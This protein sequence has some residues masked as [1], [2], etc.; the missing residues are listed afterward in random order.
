MDVCNRAKNLYS[1]CI[2]APDHCFWGIGPLAETPVKQKAYNLRAKYMVI[3]GKPSIIIA[4]MHRNKSDLFKGPN[5][6]K[7]GLNRYTASSGITQG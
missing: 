5:Y 1:L 6:G 2:Y 7:F 4:Y 3:G